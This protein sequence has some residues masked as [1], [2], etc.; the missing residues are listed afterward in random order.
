MRGGSALHEG[1]LDTEGGQVELRT[2]RRSG[3][4]ADGPGAR[5]GGRMTGGA[6]RAPASARY[7]DVKKLPQRNGAAVTEPTSTPES[8]SAKSSAPIIY[9]H[10]DEAPLLATYSFLPVIQAYAAKAGVGVETRDISLAG[11]IIASFPE[12]LTDEQRIDDALAE[13]GELARRPEANIIKL[14]NISA[15]V[16]QLKAAVAELQSQGYAVPDY[17]GDPQTDEER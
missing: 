2:R 12:R 17:P 9:T 10:P 4:G 11:R 15:S 1:R 3:M 8:T 16:P 6:R 13:L 14:P 5:G 7:L